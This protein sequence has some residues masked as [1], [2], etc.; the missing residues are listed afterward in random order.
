MLIG[1]K[2]TPELHTR[3][4]EIDQLDA[5]REVQ[6]RASSACATRLLR[7]SISPN[8][9]VYPIQSSAGSAARAMN[10]RSKR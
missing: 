1:T 7:A 6:P 5:V 10:E 2:I 9:Y 3:E 4:V 8:V